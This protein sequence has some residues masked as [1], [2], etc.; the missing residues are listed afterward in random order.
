MRNKPFC[1]QWATTDAKDVYKKKSQSKVYSSLIILITCTKCHA[2]LFFGSTVILST[3]RQAYKDKCRFS[4]NT[5]TDNQVRLPPHPLRLGNSL[6]DSSWG[7]ISQFIRRCICD[8]VPGAALSPQ[9]A[10]QEAQLGWCSCGGTAVRS[11]ETIDEP[12][13][14]SRL[15][16]DAAVIKLP[17]LI[18]FHVIAYTQTHHI[19]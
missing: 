4:Y 18:C 1:C 5:I 2:N 12:G 16:D 7:R 8:E 6:L 15:E 19:I 10:H 13:F 14:K 9:L 3:D 11:C 17:Q